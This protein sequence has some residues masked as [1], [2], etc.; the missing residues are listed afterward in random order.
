M[1]IGFRIVGTIL[2]GVVLGYLIDNAM[3][4][5]TNYFTLLFALLAL[6]VMI[7][8]LIKEFS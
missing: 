3:G 8:Q 7:Y 5:Q 2:A 1:G 4:N 6:I